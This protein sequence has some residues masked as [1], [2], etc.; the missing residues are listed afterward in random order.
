VDIAS[1][2]TTK[3]FHEHRGNASNVVRQ[4]NA[5]ALGEKADDA[6]RN[7]VAVVSN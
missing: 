6:R 7:W 4:M 5:V 1:P 2:L 3:Y